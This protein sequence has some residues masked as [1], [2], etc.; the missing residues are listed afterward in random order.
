MSRGPGRWQRAILQQLETREWILL[1]DVLPPEYTPTQV[2]ACRRALK[3]LRAQ[4]LV[5]SRRLRERGLTGE[6]RKILG[7]SVVLRPGVELDEAAIHAER[8]YPLIVHGT[9]YRL[10]G[11]V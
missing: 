5:H 4:G 8:V 3:R 11:Y 1:R 9:P 2:A 7:A 10:S 6:Q